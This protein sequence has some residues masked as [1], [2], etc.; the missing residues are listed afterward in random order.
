MLNNAAVYQDAMHDIYY[1]ITT[2]EETDGL[3]SEPLDESE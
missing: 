3:P 2:D 1:V